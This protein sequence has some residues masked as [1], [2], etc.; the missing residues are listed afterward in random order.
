MAE[1]GD[2]IAMQKDLDNEFSRNLEQLE[3]FL[4]SMKLRDKALATEWIEK[5]KKSNKNIEERKLRNRFIKHFVELTSKDKSVFSSK[6]FKNLPQYFSNP[7]GEFKSLLPLTPEEILHPTE[8]VKQTYISEL[9]TNVPEGANFLRVQPV[10]RQGSFFI[11]LIVPDDSKE[12][13]KK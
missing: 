10:P 7:L 11:L 2:E 12:T 13:G 8:E 4:V 1:G 6:P 3:K 5:L 9:L